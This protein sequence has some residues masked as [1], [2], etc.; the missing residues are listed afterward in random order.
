[1]SDLIRTTETC[2]DWSRAR[3]TPH[4]SQQIQ[5]LIK[6]N[7]QLHFDLIHQLDSSQSKDVK[8]NKII[9]KLEQKAMEQNFMNE[10]LKLKLRKEQQKLDEERK[11]MKSHQ[12]PKSGLKV[13]FNVLS[14]LGIVGLFTVELGCPHLIQKNDV[15][16]LDLLNVTELKLRECN[17]QLNHLKLEMSDINNDNSLLKQQLMTREK[18]ISRLSLKVESN[19]ERSEPVKDSQLE[20][21]MHY[22]ESSEKVI[23]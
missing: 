10:Q 4:Q 17:Q 16:A 15:I 20:F 6:E 22:Y 23:D 8:I 21:Y 13:E 3:Q 1:L 19:Q 9:K 11:K 12:Q 7:N 14:D 5:L 2:R 18:E